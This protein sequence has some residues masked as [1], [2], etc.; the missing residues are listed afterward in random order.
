VLDPHPRLVQVTEDR[1]LD[2]LA[3]ER[4]P[5]ALDLAQRLRVVR[6]GTW[7]SSPVQSRAAYRVSAKPEYG[8]ARIGFRIARDL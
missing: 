8:G 4:P 5:E 6:G 7:A 2:Q 3:P 1:A